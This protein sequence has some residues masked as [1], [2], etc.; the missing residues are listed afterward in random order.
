M[1]G[2]FR[3]SGTVSEFQYRFE[4][5]HLLGIGLG[6]RLGA[7]A[8]ASIDAGTGVGTDGDYVAGIKPQPEMAAKQRK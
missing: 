1:P 7:P 3:D 5:R 2:V 4:F 8:V 6:A